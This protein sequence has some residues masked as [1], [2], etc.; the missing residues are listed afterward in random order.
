MRLIGRLC[1]L[2]WTFARIGHGERACNDERFGD[3]I[4]F[5]RCLENAADPRVERQL[6]ELASTPRQGARRIDGIQLLQ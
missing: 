5:A 4:A 2:Q 6:R 3:A 1:A